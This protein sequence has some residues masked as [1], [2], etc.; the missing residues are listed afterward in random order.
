MN[1]GVCA[2]HSR[3][4]ALCLI[5]AAFQTSCLVFDSQVI[6]GAFFAVGAPSALLLGWLGDRYNRVYL[7]F[8]VVRTN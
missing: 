5:P 7:L 6:M 4:R 2:M 1:P 3:T 8:G